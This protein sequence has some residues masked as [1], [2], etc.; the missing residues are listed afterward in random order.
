MQTSCKCLHLGS[1][2]GPDTLPPKHEQIQCRND[3]WEII[4]LFDWEPLVSLCQVFFRMTHEQTH[5]HPPTPQVP[6]PFPAHRP[7][8]LGGSGKHTRA[9]LTAPAAV[10]W[11]LLSLKKKPFGS[12]CCAAK[13]RCGGKL[14]RAAAMETK[15]SG[16]ESRE[17]KEGPYFSAAEGTADLK[18]PGLWTDGPHSKNVDNSKVFANLKS[19]IKRDFFF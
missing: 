5:K 3:L 8:L 13:L 14:C 15:P 2:A 7:L 6:A 10:I 19:A 9:G 12:F 11:R 1:H 16:T 17:T 18:N 4:C